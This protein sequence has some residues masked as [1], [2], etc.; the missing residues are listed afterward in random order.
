[1]PSIVP[2]P[3]PMLCSSPQCCP[4]SRLASPRFYDNDVG[5]PIDL[6]RFSTPSSPPVSAEV[7][8]R[9]HPS[10]L[11]PY[12]S[13]LLSPPPQVHAQHH[14]PIMLST[15]YGFM[16]T[17]SPATP[18]G[19]PVASLVTPKP[20]QYGARSP[21]PS[22]SPTS[23]LVPQLSKSGK[24]S[25]GGSKHTDSSLQIHE[26][27]SKQILKKMSSVS[28]L[29]SRQAATA[30]TEGS[31]GTNST[32]S[33]STVPS[34]PSSPTA[35]AHAPS[36][37]RH[38]FPS[39]HSRRHSGSSDL[40]GSPLDAEAVA[41]GLVA[42][43]LPDSLPTT[44]KTPLAVGAISHAGKGQSPKMPFR[45]LLKA[46]SGFKLHHA[47]Q[48]RHSHS[49]EE[50]IDDSFSK[51]RAPFSLNTYPALWSQADEA[52]VLNT[53]SPSATKRPL[54]QRGTSE[55][56]A[57]DRPSSSPSVSSSLFVHG[58]DHRLQAP[59][60]LRSQSHSV[61]RDEQWQSHTDGH[62]IVAS[63]I[64]DGIDVSAR[65]A[66]GSGEDD[67]TM[68]PITSSA[69]PFNTSIDEGE[70]E[71]CHPP[72]DHE[73]L[74][75]LFTSPTSSHA[76]LAAQGLIF[77]S[78]NTIRPKKSNERRRGFTA[79]KQKRG[80]GRSIVLPPPSAPPT[81]PLPPLPRTKQA[82]SSVGTL[83]HLSL[84]L[85][86]QDC[87]VSHPDLMLA[88]LPSS[89]VR[90]HT[91]QGAHQDPAVPWLSQAPSAWMARSN[92][93][94]HHRV[95]ITSSMASPNKETTVAN[96]MLKTPAPPSMALKSI[97]MRQTRS[98]ATS[99]ASQ[100]MQRSASLPEPRLCF[101]ETV[102]DVFFDGS[103]LDDD[104]DAEEC[105]TPT[106]GSYATVPHSLPSSRH[107]LLRF[108]AEVASGIA[109]GRSTPAIPR[110]S[111]SLVALSEAYE[112]QALDNEGNTT[113][114]TLG[115]SSLSSSPSSKGPDTTIL[116]L[117][118]SSEDSE[119]SYL[120]PP[121]SSFMPRSFPTGRPSVSMLGTGKVKDKSKPKIEV[122][123]GDTLVE[124]KEATVESSSPGEASESMSASS[125]SPWELKKIQ[126]V[127][128]DESFVGRGRSV[129]H[130]WDPET[131]V[132]QR[133]SQQD[134][135]N[136]A[137]ILS[138]L[139]LFRLPPD[140]VAN[141]DELSESQQSKK[142][143][144]IRRW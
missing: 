14:L 142:I 90:R 83:P 93:K 13:L 118:R 129:S 43:H 125:S 134:R 66:S 117:G 44:P 138:S 139:S 100:I 16:Q 106:S 75:Q 30:S 127:E 45:R 130:T 88:S 60:M 85:E 144:L 91:A 111:G 67:R 71:S 137:L 19:S 121:S 22:P 9:S 36:L 76:W 1:M 50:H 123:F 89:P 73:T 35:A 23:F 51:G 120:P 104:D 79:V 25:R 55:E 143:R 135:R 96:D 131:E 49:T 72:S 63:Q 37:A 109:D 54:P 27:T 136:R 26:S 59:L 99:F 48:H 58:K 124:S 82:T 31:I 87:E 2:H 7:S 28:R 110:R 95:A 34:I 61:F 84:C 65:A 141:R 38:H 62:Q 108:A 11:P 3:P 56:Q 17:A 41:L 77:S 53:R 64:G 81:G 140:R 128:L 80:R 119:L 8:V 52:N 18:A 47:F 102:N 69:L 114:E 46:P 98:A 115:S 122:T 20:N 32:F 132:S 40:W 12:A 86:A 15:T 133:V 6:Q 126:S 5:L 4:G 57:R 105:Q 70:V 116:A 101:V 68:G 24:T 92:G 103:Q 39:P 29:R 107:S 10:S 74:E 21:T 42:P 78:P 112:S 97:E 94:R 113:Q 33:T